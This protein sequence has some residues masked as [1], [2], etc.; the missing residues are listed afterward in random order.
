MPHIGAYA[1]PP[2]ASPTF[3]VPRVLTTVTFVKTGSPTVVMC[4][5][6]ITDTAN[7][8]GTG[9]YMATG[10]YMDQVHAQCPGATFINSGHAGDG[11]NTVAAAVK[12]RILDHAPDI[13]I[14]EI[15]INNWTRQD[16]ASILGPVRGQFPNCQIACVS[17]LWH[18]E[19]WSSGPPIIFSN[20]ANDSTLYTNNI[21]INDLCIQYGCVY[22]DMRTQ[23]ATYES[24]HNTPEPGVTTGII[25]S[26]GVHPNTTGQLLM[27]TYMMAQTAFV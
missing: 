4:G 12:T 10:G 14:L 24:T 26:D 22:V 20:G 19:Q 23:A 2:A 11:T 17:I 13:L 25:T 15:G 5:D 8:A 3:V 9:W 1:V 6:S 16:Y 7:P 21:E 27:G 18:N